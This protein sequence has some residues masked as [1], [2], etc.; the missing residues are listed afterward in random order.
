ME[1]LFVV[2]TVRET[3]FKSTQKLLTLSVTT[4][5]ERRKRRKHDGQQQTKNIDVF[6]VTKL[7]V[8]L[9]RVCIISSLPIYS[10]LLV[11]SPLWSRKFA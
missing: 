5:A 7:V 8:L 3:M 4:I 1:R 6:T 10:D 2:Q 9:Q 11:V